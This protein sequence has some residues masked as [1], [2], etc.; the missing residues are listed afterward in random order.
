MAPV[1]AVLMFVLNKKILYT[2]MRVNLNERTIASDDCKH[3]GS[4]HTN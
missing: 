4:I 3:R 1:S 2:A